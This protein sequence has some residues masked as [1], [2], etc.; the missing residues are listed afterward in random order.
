M[1]EESYAEIEKGAKGG[2]KAGKASADQET[3]QAQKAIARAAANMQNAVYAN[4]ATSRQPV[5]V[6]VKLSGDAAD[7]FK[8]VSAEEEIFYKSTGKGRFDHT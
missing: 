1:A 4:G 6:T 3:A 2:G 5:N 8:A 7:I